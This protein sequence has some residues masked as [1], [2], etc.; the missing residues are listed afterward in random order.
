MILVAGPPCGG[1]TTYVAEHRTPGQNIV[2]F[3]DIV[4]MLGKPRYEAGPEIAEQARR[5][6][7]ASLPMADWVIWTAPRRQDRGRF[8]GQFGAQVV[9]VMA[10]MEECLDRAESRPVVW[11][12]HI[13]RWFAIWEPSRSGSET[14]IR[15]DRV[16]A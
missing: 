13:R 11:Q 14:I 1:K 16:A 3:D 10:S 7:V 4:E 6:W 12:E 5:I 2:D 15:T 9:V 8:R